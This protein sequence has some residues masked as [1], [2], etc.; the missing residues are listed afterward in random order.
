MLKYFDTFS[1]KMGK[2][3]LLFVLLSFLPAQLVWGDI[4]GKIAGKVVDNEGKPLPG[5]NIMLEGTKRGSA[6]NNKGKY[7]ILS[8][9]PGIYTVSASMIGYDKII[10][11][12]VLV[13]SGRTT[14]IDFVLKE[15]VLDL[16]QE[17]VVTAERPVIEVDRTSTEFILNSKEIEQTPLIQSVSGLMRYMPGVSLD[18]SDRMIVRGGDN[19][20]INMYYDGIPLDSYRDINIFSVEEASITTGGVGAEYGNAQGGVINV[21]TKDGSANYHATVEYGLSPPRQGHWGANYWDDAYHLDNTFNS[22]LRWDDPAWANEIDSLTGRKVHE[23]IDYTAIW[24]QSIKLAVSGP[25]FHPAL[26]HKIPFLKNFYFSYATQFSQGSGG[27]ISV[28]RYSLPYTRNNWKLTYKAHPN[29]TFRSGGFYNWS[30][31]YNSGGN[32]GSGVG[33]TTG[34]L[35]SQDIEGAIRGMR[36]GNGGQYTDDRNIFLP[37]DY[38]GGGKRISQEYLAYL[39]MVHIINPS[40][41]YDL[42][43]YRQQSTQDNQGVPDTV[44]TKARTDQDGWYY[45][46]GGRGISYTD[47]KTIRTGAKLDFSSQ[48][49][50]H[51]LIKLGVDYQHY[52]VW[53]TSHY[54]NA[55]TVRKL[56]RIC[57]NFETGQ[58]ITPTKIAAYLSDKMEF[59][60]L[61]VNIGGRFDYFDWGTEFPV[62]YA[63]SKLNRVYNSFTRFRDLPKELWYEPEPLTAF[64]PRLGLSHPISEK[65][66]IHFF[67][68]HVYQLPSFWDMYHDEWVAMNAKNP[69]KD[70]N[71]NGVTDEAEVYNRLN[72]RSNRLRYGNPT[73]DYEETTSFEMGVDWNFYQDYILTTTTYYKSAQ[74]QVKS[75]SVHQFWDPNRKSTAPY[76]NIKNNTQYEDA[77]GFEFLLKK[78]FSRVFSFQVSFN[79]AWATDGWSGERVRTYIPDGSFVEKYYFEKYDGDTNGDGEENGLDSGAEVPFIDEVQERLIQK[80]ITAADEYIAQLREQGAN[81]KMVDGIDGLYY[82]STHYSSVGRP[83]ANVERRTS[84]GLILY[85]DLPSDFGPAISGFRPLA[86]IHANLSYQHH[87]GLPYQYAS[88]D[89]LAL[90]RSAPMSSNAN[91]RIEKSIHL[92]G[93]TSTL[94]LSISNLFNEQ[95]LNNSGSFDN[96]VSLRDYV[97]YGLEGYSPLYD[98]DYDFRGKTDGGIYL[99]SPRSYGF[100]LRF[101][102]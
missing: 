86:N 43:V 29:L 26:H 35:G 63:L 18:G 41:Y 37:F 92:G 68:G 28:T 75:G 50:S 65:A 2:L 100:G 21:V 101:N 76:I 44:I 22:R 24:S 11:T 83:R 98:Y 31:G 77:K 51:H 96:I 9:P 39:S 3:I 48:I 7:F 71:L 69:D 87:E 66:T 55:T 67:Y 34:G 80:R 38:S 88:L 59:G 54:F 95:A 93:I 73:M 57:K 14:T 46:E 94:F 10:Q 36:I 84:F 40:T 42:K 45:I 20:D 62:T 74:N 6:A 53:Q 23:K 8:V 17:V 49:T 27:S 32:V 97:N 72:D 102:F 90:W 89:G 33:F 82:V 64:S 78:R 5:V 19:I 60:G 56:S 85:L 30:K 12:R 61:V 81:L 15:A 52:D 99:G 70:V 4:S 1:E 58:A 16:G 13:Q 91:L 25:L 47:A 79:L